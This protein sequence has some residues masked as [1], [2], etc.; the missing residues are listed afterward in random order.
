[1]NSKLE[2]WQWLEGIIEDLKYQC[3]S[4][5]HNTNVLNSLICI[6][7]YKV[8]LEVKQLNEEE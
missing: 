4:G 2:E 7:K 3:K 1:M 6:L 5:V 8:E